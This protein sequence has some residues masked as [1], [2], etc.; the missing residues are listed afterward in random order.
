MWEDLLLDD[1]LVYRWMGLLP[2][3]LIS[4]TQQ[5]MYFGHL[6]KLPLN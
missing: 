1:F 4:Y 3:E 6:Q 5:F 2:E